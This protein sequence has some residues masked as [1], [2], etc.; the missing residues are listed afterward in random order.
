MDISNRCPLLS[1]AQVTVEEIKTSPKK[2]FTCSEW[3]AF[4]LTLKQ[5]LCWWVGMEQTKHWLCFPSLEVDA[6]KQAKTW[7][8]SQS[9]TPYVQGPPSSSAAGASTALQE[10]PQLTSGRTSW[11]AHL[12]AAGNKLV[13]QGHIGHTLQRGSKLWVGAF[14][15]LSHWVA[16]VQKGF[17][18][19]CLKLTWIHMSSPDSTDVTQ[20]QCGYSYLVEW[21]LKGYQH[22]V[23]T[24]L[25]HLNHS[26]MVWLQS[27]NIVLGFF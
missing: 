11:S 18:P 12:P 6:S 16:E 24:P 13:P 5:Q 27:V 23:M 15:Y 4:L 9:C 22:K 7:V 21:L 19:K 17:Y 10:L 25:I 2:P 20:T 3:T 14:F 1:W 26:F 8:S